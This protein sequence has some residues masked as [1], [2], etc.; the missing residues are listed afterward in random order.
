MVAAWKVLK[1]LSVPQGMDGAQAR[2]ILWSL[3]SREIYRMLV[4]ERGWSSEEYQEWLGRSL[5]KILVES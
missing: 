4:I 5:L 1:M 2:N 3:T